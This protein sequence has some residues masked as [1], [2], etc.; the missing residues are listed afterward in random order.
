VSLEKLA[1]TKLILHVVDLHAALEDKLL[2][3]PSH[4]LLTPCNTSSKEK[5]SSLTPKKPTALLEQRGPAD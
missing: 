4:H 1:L 5:P 3:P 2:T